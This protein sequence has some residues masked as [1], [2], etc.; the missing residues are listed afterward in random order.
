MIY[1]KRLYPFILTLSVS[2]MLAACATAEIRTRAVSY[3]EALADF[4]NKQILLNAVRASKRYPVYYS[5]LGDLSANEMVDG[6]IGGAFPFS[7][8]NGRHI[9]LPG[10]TLSP[11]LN[12]GSGIG[13]FNVGNLNTADFQ[14]AIHSEISAAFFK[15]FIKAS[16][17]KQLLY[18][19]MVKDIKISEDLDREIH[20]QAFENC[21]KLDRQDI[22][23]LSSHE[24]RSLS[25]CNHIKSGISELNQI[26]SLPWPQQGRF[27]K[28]SHFN[29][30]TNY[31]SRLD[32]Q[33]FVWQM[34]LL[35]ARF[36]STKPKTI[37]KVLKETVVTKDRYDHGHSG[38]T[39]KELKH[40][41]ISSV[42]LQLILGNRK[43]SIGGKGAL[44]LRSA[45]Q[46]IQ[47]LGQLV[48]AQ[49]FAEQSFTPTIL[50]GG[51]RDYVSVPL[52]EVRSDPLGLISAAVRVEHEGRIYYIPKPDYGQRTEARSLQ[53]LALINQVIAF[54]TNRKDLP[55]SQTLQ[56]VAN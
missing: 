32:Y 43:F 56:L 8:S 44:D 13:S 37:K 10:F 27:G 20:H 38:Y 25:L 6:K 15:D 12:I 29:S 33:I 49:L 22:G 42:Q 45:H 48:S 41:T 39:K 26:C 47:Y 21:R 53:V 51:L 50:I 31:C 2:V 14:K 16:W 30:G 23:L 24:Q 5:A 9:E 4:G 55:T 36:V 7:I 11:N 1:I 3:N 46:M 52:F 17:P 34:R 40:A 28:A 19:L 35:G 18:A 54:Q